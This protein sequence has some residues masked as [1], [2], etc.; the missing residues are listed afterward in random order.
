MPLDC[1]CWPVPGVV[2][3]M[4]DRYGVQACDV[5]S[6]DLSDLDA[7]LRLAQLIGGE[8]RFWQHDAE[9]Q[10]L[11]ELMYDEGEAYDLAE[12]GFE[13]R[14]YANPARPDDCIL[15]RT[16]PWVELDGDRVNWNH[17]GR[18]SEALSRGRGEVWG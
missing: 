9:R 15:T 17:V 16:D 7:A 6:F 8:V 5:C 1:D 14:W 3:P 10:D 11:A 12:I 13:L 18:F 4:N 2:A